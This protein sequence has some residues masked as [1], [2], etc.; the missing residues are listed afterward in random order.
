MHWINL[1]S[2][3]QC[4][5]YSDKLS[6]AIK[7]LMMMQSILQSRYDNKAKLNLGLLDVKHVKQ[8]HV[9]TLKL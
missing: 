1:N 7:L 5:H 3:C 4:D 6:A 8:L 2:Y 9:V